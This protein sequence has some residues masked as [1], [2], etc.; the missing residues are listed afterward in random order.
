[1]KF[2]SSDSRVLCSNITAGGKAILKDIDIFSKDEQ[3]T[4]IKSC[5]L[6]G[7]NIAGVDII[8]NSDGIYLFETNN[9]PGLATACTLEHDYHLQAITNYF[10]E[11]KYLTLSEKFV[12]LPQIPQIGDHRAAVG[13]LYRNQVI[14]SS[15]KNASTLLTELG[16]EDG[17]KK[18]YVTL[19][20]HK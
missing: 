3:Y 7:V 11:I 4:I 1:M 8:K 9:S 19:R 15:K 2:I 5:K 13:V 10:R 12:G 6:M 17:Q 16:F 20:Q 18:A 14:A